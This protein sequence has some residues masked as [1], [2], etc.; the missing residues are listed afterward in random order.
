MGLKD[1]KREKPAQEEAIRDTGNIETAQAVEN[2][3]HQKKSKSASDLAQWQ[4]A[5]HPGNAA[6]LSIYR[7][8]SL[9]GMQ[10]QRYIKRFYRHIERYLR[11]PFQMLRFG[12]R[13]VFVTVDRYAFRAY[14]EAADEAEV[15]AGRDA[16][17]AF[18]PEA[19]HKKKARCRRFLCWGIM[20][21]KQSSVIRSC[22]EHCL[23]QRC[24]LA[25]VCCLQRQWRIGGVSP[26][27][28]K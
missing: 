10:T 7:W 4:D 26:L 28:W 19:M 2:K 24:P 16:Q 6:L 21:Q 1:A 23:I 11:L 27:R 17:C 9:V 25:R 12:G 8:V 3:K 22:L 15:S 14:H 20:R 18:E 5:K 13:F